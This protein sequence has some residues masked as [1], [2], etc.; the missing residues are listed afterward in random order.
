MAAHRP[1]PRSVRVGGA[2]ARYASQADAS[3]HQGSA[4][5]MQLQLLMPPRQVLSSAAAGADRSAD[6]DTRRSALF[7]GHGWMR[8]QGVREPV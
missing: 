4:T 5:G 8:R 1:G 2:R 6:S 7:C 3:R